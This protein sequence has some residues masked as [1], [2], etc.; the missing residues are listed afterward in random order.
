MTKITGILPLKDL[1]VK[2]LESCLAKFCDKHYFDRA[3]P[4]WGIDS[5]HAQECR[6][7]QIDKIKT[8][9]SKD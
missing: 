7:A 2:I 8:E 1:E 6:Q 5:A 3:T 4:M 9:R